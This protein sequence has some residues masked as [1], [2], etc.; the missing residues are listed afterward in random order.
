MIEMHGLKFTKEFMSAINVEST[1]QSPG[2]V[3]NAY[4]HT[5]KI[6]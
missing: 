1:W 5:C 4:L 3:T 2:K 6:V